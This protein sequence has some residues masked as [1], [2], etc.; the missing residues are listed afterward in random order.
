MKKLVITSTIIEKSE[1]DIKTGIKKEFSEGLNVIYGENEAGK[2]SLSDFIRNGL[3]GEKCADSGKIYFCI[4]DDN[5][6]NNYRADYKGNQKPDSRIKLYDEAGNNIDNSLL[7]DAVNKKYFE[8]GFVINLDELMN[9]QNKD[10]ATLTD[11]IKDPTGTLLNDFTD[12]IKS[13]AKKLFGDNNKP[14]KELTGILKEIDYLDNEINKRLN[15]ESEYNNALNAIR[16]SDEKLEFI[17]EKGNLFK[18][19]KDVSEEQKIF[20]DLNEQL[21]ILNSEFNEKL[22]VNRNIYLEI[23]KNAGIYDSNIQS[24]E[25]LKENIKNL[26]EKISETYKKIKD[27]YSVN[28]TNE[29]IQNLKYDD[30]RIRKIKEFLTKKEDTEKELTA[31]ISKTEIIQETIK[32]LK[33]DIDFVKSE[34]IPAE[35]YDNLKNIYEN[36]KTGL[37]QYGEILIRLNAV[38]DKDGVLPAKSKSGI[39]IFSLLL[40]TGIAAFVIAFANKN[41]FGQILSVPTTLF[42][43]TGILIFTGN[44]SNVTEKEHL[45]KLKSSVT[46][47]LKTEAQKYD[48]RIKTDEITYLTVKLNDIKQEIQNK[49]QNR[50]SETKKCIDKTRELKSLEE[51]L[52][53]NKNLIS[54]K[55]TEL[56][57]I[58]SEISKIITET[59]FDSSLKGERFINLIDTSAY[60]KNILSQ[61]EAAE[62]EIKEKLKQNTEI[63]GF[64]NKFIYEND[65]NISVGENFRENISNL[66]EYDEKNTEIKSRLNELNVKVEISAKKLEEMKFFIKEYENRGIKLSSELSEFNLNEEKENILKIKKEAEYTR[67]NLEEYEGLG[68]LK[69][70]RE[71]L[72]QEYRKKVTELIKYKTII[73]IT[74]KAK[75]NFNKIQPCLNE[76]EKY[77][78]ILTNGKY[79][80]INLNSEEIS[81]GNETEIKKWINLSRGTKE[82]LYLALRLGYASNYSKNTLTG[83][84]KNKPSLPLITDDAFVNFDEQRTKNAFKCLEEFSKT[85]Q[86]LFFTCHKTETLNNIINKDMI[87]MIEI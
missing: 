9:I 78:S 79:E 40:I 32:K 38:N 25:S 8:Q 63:T 18:I 21:S 27:E 31:I 70:K 71:L 6:Q 19:L 84:E 4:K 69:I 65:I 80:K 29:L 14:T 45:T 37:E 35:E 48:N 73:A 39:I 47:D 81:N 57:E 87:N 51:S 16:I 86:V 24:I 23:M 41:Q 56:K 11:V 12:N 54:E 67:K 82:Q 10:T 20:N 28:L 13:K 76:A 85:N 30:T 72:L 58:D 15:N 55:E 44:K 83:E 5:S 49:L 46:A 3:T 62:N 75:N 60:L 2:S 26:S 53:G 74:E 64:L 43:L 61:C 36:I 52:S 66:K 17:K 33:S 42:A 34:I 50:D 68:E 1:K 77:L 59:G 7:T 22:S